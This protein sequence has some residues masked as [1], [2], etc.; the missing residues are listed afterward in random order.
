MGSI[1]VRVG[2][3]PWLRLLPWLRLWV[4]LLPQRLQL[5]RLLLLL[6]LLLMQLLW[7]LLLPLLSALLVVRLLQS[8][9]GEC[10][11]TASRVLRMTDYYTPTPRADNSPASR[12]RDPASPAHSQTSQ[13]TACST[14]STPLTPEHDSVPST[15]RGLTCPDQLGSDAS[16]YAPTTGAAISDTRSGSAPPS[17]DV[18]VRSENLGGVKFSGCSVPAVAGDWQSTV[19]ATPR[20]ASSSFDSVNAATIPHTSRTADTTDRSTDGS[21]WS[22]TVSPPRPLSNTAATTTDGTSPTTPT[23]LTYAQALTGD[24]TTPPAPPTAVPT[25][26]SG[27]TAPAPAP[28]HSPIRQTRPNGSPTTLAPAHRLPAPTG[29]PTDCTTHGEEAPAHAQSAQLAR[30][31][32]EGAL[33]P[34]SQGQT[35]ALTSPA[36]NPT[37]ASHR[38]EARSDTQIATVCG[39]DKGSPHEATPSDLPPTADDARE[40]MVV[41]SGQG[42]NCLLHSMFGSPATEED[43]EVR[44]VAAEHWQMLTVYCDFLDFYS[45]PEEMHTEAMQESARALMEELW[46]KAHPGRSTVPPQ[47]AERSTELL[48]NLWRSTASA[49]A[50]ADHQEARDLVISSFLDA[51]ETS[52]HSGARRA[53]LDSEAYTLPSL[54]QWRGLV[55]AY[56]ATQL[57]AERRAGLIT[58]N[59]DGLQPLL[60]ISSPL[61]GA[62]L[63]FYQ[64]IQELAPDPAVTDWWPECVSYIRGH[65]SDYFF[66]ENSL[67]FLAELCQERV[68][69]CAIGS[70]QPEPNQQAVRVA[71]SSPA[72]GEAGLRNVSTDAVFPRDASLFPRPHPALRVHVRNHFDRVG[73]PTDRADCGPS[74][75]VPL[76]SPAPIGPPIASTTAPQVPTSQPTQPRSINS[77]MGVTHQADHPG[78]YNWPNFEELSQHVQQQRKA[79][80]RD[81]GMPVSPTTRFAYVYAP[82]NANLPQNRR[83]LIATQL[84]AERRSPRAS[85]PIEAKPPSRCYC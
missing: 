78:V 72:P 32:S 37:Q 18:A 25:A 46:P 2:S 62:F 36:T 10:L 9:L 12:A 83:L 31:S 8:L 21:E 52:T 54:G 30:T 75:P 70:G 39:S 45:G 60:P 61:R 55:A 68:C 57:P 34:P 65:Q 44:L 48:S 11:S 51:P 20:E 22:T 17:F 26:P 79:H 53:F 69:I 19:L 82:S 38:G 85:R 16:P 80:L 23:T 1:A 81:N 28:T 77:N 56:D 74:R 14:T 73:P 42:N 6:W 64:H 41:A 24:H 71:S 13:S 76:Q 49:L 7:L 35:N 50:E 66:S 43:G 84:D 33:T 5:P 3:R 4:L 47:Q 15:A 29:S 59:W 67:P 58:V 63:D 27:Q 40:R